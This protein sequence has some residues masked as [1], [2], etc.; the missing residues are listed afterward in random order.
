MKTNSSFSPNP[1][2]LQRF[3]IRYFE[4]MSEC[5][6]RSRYRDERAIRSLGH[7]K[8]QVLSIPSSQLDRIHPGLL[9]RSNQLLQ[10]HQ[11]NPQGLRKIHTESFQSLKQ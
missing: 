2:R 4:G 3:G 11:V 9:K 1:N 7:I 5:L 6:A 10:H 8:Q